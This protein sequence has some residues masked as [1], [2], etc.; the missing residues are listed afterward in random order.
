[1]LARAYGG[2]PLEAMCLGNGARKHQYVTAKHSCAA[3][4]SGHLGAVDDPFEDP[5][6]YKNKTPEQ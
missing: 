3:W 4:E 1:M 5:S 2:G 6:R